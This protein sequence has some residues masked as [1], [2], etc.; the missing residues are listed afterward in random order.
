MTANWIPIELQLPDD[1]LEVL[2]YG[3]ALEN[4][5]LGY[6]DTDGWFAVDGSR[7]EVT[8]WMHLPASPG[9]TFKDCHETL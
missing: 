7:I 3:P 4:V 1:D 8:H 6:M 2:V 9:S 5:W